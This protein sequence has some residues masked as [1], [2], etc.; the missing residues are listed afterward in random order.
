M[1]LI[2]HSIDQQVQQPSLG[3]ELAVKAFKKQFEALSKLL[4]VS[5]NRLAVAPAL[6]SDDLITVNSLDEA[7]DDGSKTNQA[8]GLSL[9]KAIKA[10]I[11][12]QPI[13]SLKRLINV[14]KRVEPF[15]HIAHKLTEDAHL[16]LPF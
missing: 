1:I 10:T 15:E 11:N 12:E 9:M 16:Q 14:F 2:I 4:S 7:I 3:P 6:Y 8:K 13:E 5:S